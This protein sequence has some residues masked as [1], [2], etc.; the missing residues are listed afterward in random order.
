VSVTVV[1]APVQPA[2]IETVTPIG[3]REALRLGRLIRPKRVS[4]LMFLGEDAACALGAMA[5]GWGFDDNEWAAYHF[6]GERLATF[7]LTIGGVCFPFDAAE[8][9]GR[10]GDD[11]VLANLAERGL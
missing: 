2:P 1:E 11:A 4:C 7:G 3:P 10:N 6:L 8:V 5:L 9:Q